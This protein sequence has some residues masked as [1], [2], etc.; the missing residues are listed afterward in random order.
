M[1]E[2][3]WP[4]NAQM[5]RKSVNYAS[6]RRTFFKAARL[7]VRELASFDDEES[8]AGGFIQNRRQFIHKLTSPGGSITASLNFPRSA[9][10]ANVKIWAWSRYLRGACV[11][12][13]DKVAIEAARRGVNL[14]PDSAAADCELRHGG[15]RLLNAPPCKRTTQPIQKARAEAS[16]SQ[17]RENTKKAPAIL[18][19]VLLCIY[20]VTS[21]GRREREKY[22]FSCI[23]QASSG[24][25]R[26]SIAVRRTVWHERQI[27][28]ISQDYSFLLRACE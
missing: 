9:F 17:K 18:F 7:N 8:D 20:Y 25:S 5:P 27:V 1:F 22:A 11:W 26:I 21:R 24:A 10:S 12:K 13:K 16:Y 3:C 14:S 28:R 2:S 6:T 15:V 19:C 4:L 23:K